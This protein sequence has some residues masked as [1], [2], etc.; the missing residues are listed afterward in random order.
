MVR[1]LVGGVVRFLV[2]GVE[3]LLLAVASVPG[4]LGVAAGWKG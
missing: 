1:F 3:L 4:I 2:G